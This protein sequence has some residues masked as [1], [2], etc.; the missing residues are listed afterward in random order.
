MILIILGPPGAGKGTQACR[1]VDTRGLVQL[2]TGD[3]LRAAVA[4]ASPIGLEAKAAMD[5]GQLV[6]D[7]IVVR[8]IGQR[9]AE[10][11]G[12]SG[13]I[14]DGFPRN[15]AQA[16]ALDAMLAEQELSVD[17]VVELDVDNA[18]ITQRIAGRFTCADCNEGY[19]DAFKP[20]KVDGVCDVCG[21]GEFIRR[22]DDNEKTVQARLAAYHEQTAPLSH[23]YAQMGVLKHVDGMAGIGEVSRQID[24]V[25]KAA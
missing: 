3:M 20:T 7:D 2:A 21:G 12:E 22:P 11:D 25:L 4:S 10:G 17:L 13:Y 15:V 23:Y 24:E 18:A 5:A 19:H 9:I 6:S 8:I 14:L 1:L 16:E